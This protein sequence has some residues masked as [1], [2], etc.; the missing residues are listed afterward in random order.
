MGMIVRR[1][2][3]TINLDG[4]TSTMGFAVVV[5]FKPNR[6]KRI[7]ETHSYNIALS[8]IHDGVLD[9]LVHSC[10]HITLSNCFDAN[11]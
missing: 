8:F 3:D 2:M 10:V 5:P 9:L 4:E 7:R 6:A 1:D 11:D